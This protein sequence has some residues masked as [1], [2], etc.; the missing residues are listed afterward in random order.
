VA[1]QSGDP[2][3]RATWRQ[4][5]EVS[6]IG[7]NAACA[8]LRV[9]LTDDD[10]AGE[11]SYNDMLPAVCETLEQKDIAVMSDGALCVFFDKYTGREGKPTPLIIRKSDGGYGYGTTDLATIK[12]RVED[13][14]AD[15]ILYV[16]G[17]PQALHLNMVFDTATAAG[18]LPEDVPAIHVKIG[19]VLGEDR[20]ILRT[21]SG[22]PLPL[23]TLLTE[24]IAKAR[25]HI[26]DARPDLSDEERENIARQIGIGAVKYADLSVAHDSEYVF[27]LERMMALTGNTGPYLQYA[28]T[29]IRSMFRSIDVDPATYEAEIHITEAPERALAVQLLEFG[30]VV[31]AV[32]D[33]LEPH[34]LCAYLF[35]LAQAFMAFYENC[36]V[37]KADD[38][39]VKASR[40]MLCAATLRVIVTGLDLLGIEAPERM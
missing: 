32:G 2:E 22:A 3:T 16:I 18:W 39:K 40:L 33:E 14:H 30:H 31:A 19:N 25:A 38:E 12:H 24:S 29:R 8:R 34:R 35:E 6:L 11:S 26:D 20:K 15:R 23:M 13:L 17:A 1:L 9:L 7:F 27:D 10:L 28:A 5:I 36:P 37:L 21:R 4:L